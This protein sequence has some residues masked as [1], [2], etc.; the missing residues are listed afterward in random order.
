MTSRM[1]PRILAGLVL[2][3]LFPGAARGHHGCGIVVDGDRD[4]VYFLDTYRNLV[5]SLHADG[6][7]ERFGPGVHASTLSLDPEGNLYVDDFSTRL[8]RIAPD[9]AATQLLGEPEGP[10][11]VSLERGARVGDWSTFLA[12]DRE[13]SLYFRTGN[14]FLERP[15]VLILKLSG[16][17]GATTLAGGAPGHADGIG[18]AARFKA[19]FAA[20]W[21]ADGSLY[22]TDEDAIRRVTREGVVS[23]LARQAG[24]EP[25]GVEDAVPFR[26]L[27]GISVD[28]DGDVFA[29]DYG[30]RRVVKVTPGGEAT[31]VYRSPRL[32]SPSGVA[33]AAGLR[34]LFVL[35]DGYYPA[36]A[37]RAP[38]VRRVSADGSVTT[39]ATVHGLTG[40]TWIFLTKSTLTLIAAGLLFR[41]LQ[42]IWRFSTS[43]KR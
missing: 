31:T 11:R 28:A 8:L 5:W 39:V 2:C 20:A 41:L 42:R 17:G 33:V 21:G 37:G 24:S 43:R 23:T 38:R 26:V 36:L 19:A 13:G 7:L 35:E 40:T 29:A 27:R 10:V 16:E 1:V 3:V 6:R 12:V 34:G 25:G 14:D 18:S 4:R 15:D 30:N 22:L 9:G 32:W